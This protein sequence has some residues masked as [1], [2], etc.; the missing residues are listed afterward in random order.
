MLRKLNVHYI[1][2]NGKADKNAEV[3]YRAYVQEGAKIG[4]NVEIKPFAV[5]LAGAVIED[6]CIIKGCVMAD[7]TTIAEGQEL[8]NEKVGM[9]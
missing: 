1:G 5:I 3:G 6:N 9:R 8:S 7:G 4:R 2:E